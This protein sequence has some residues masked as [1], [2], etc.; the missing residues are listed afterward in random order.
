MADRKHVLNFHTFFIA[1]LALSI[2]CM[3][4]FVLAFGYDEG[5]IAGPEGEI[6][7][8]IFLI[9]RFPVVMLTGEL[10]GLF[11]DVVFYAVL[12]TILAGLFR[13]YILRP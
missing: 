6:G 11:F 9:F 3:V 4:S 5:T 8:A 12:I 1:I 13:R 7:Y 10:F 2:L